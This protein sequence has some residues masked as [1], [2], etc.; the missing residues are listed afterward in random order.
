MIVP[1]VVIPMF[2]GFLLIIVVT[3]VD[4]FVFFFSIV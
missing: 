2:L 1:V 3:S 4:F